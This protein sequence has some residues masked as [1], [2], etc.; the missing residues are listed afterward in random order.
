MIPLAIGYSETH[1][2]FG[3]ISPS[4]LYRREPEVIFDM[5]ARLAPG[6]DLPVMLLLNNIHCFP[7]D[8][9]SV[10][11]VVTAPKLSPMKI[12]ISSPAEFEIEHP[13]SFR[14]TLFHFTVP[15]DF[16]NKGWNSLVAKVEFKLKRR[17]KTVIVDNLFSSSNRPLS[18]FVAS[19]KFPGEDK[20][21]FGDFHTH[22]IHS[23][24][25]VEFGA[26]LATIIKMGEATGLKFTAVTDHSYDLECDPQNYL[27]RDP[28]LENWNV[29]Q[30]C[31]SETDSFTL[32]T[33]EEVSG[34]RDIGGVVHLGA[35][36]HN[37]FIKGSGDGARKK[38]RR[39]EEP[40]LQD[41]A[42]QVVEEGGITFAA[43][44]GEKTSLLQRIL[45]RRGNWVEN[46]LSPFVT[47]LQGI[48][49]KFDSFWYVTRKLW[50]KALLNGKHMPLIAGNDAHGD[51]NR[52]RAMGFPFLYIKENFERYYG[53][54]RTGIYGDD[55]SQ[56]ATLKAVKEGRT[57]ITDGPYVAICLEN[58]VVVGS[59]CS[60]D[61]QFCIDVES[62]EEFG[63]LRKITL[64]AGSYTTKKE[65][66][67]ILPS[68]KD[69]FSYQYS[70]TNDTLCD[71]DY[72][73]VE[74][75]CNEGKRLFASKAATSPVY[76]M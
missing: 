18:V 29:Q 65:R 28:T 1:F 36:G 6:N 22:S 4:L 73:R 19:D 48:N 44:P 33:G 62:T 50:V 30:D 59:Q 61:D 13:F 51:F 17:N 14:A 35:L 3:G 71:F 63:S 39:N 8:V 32:I 42:K 72:I 47:S 57:F 45:L 43:H 46:E 25:H 66:V 54:G 20:S 58:R 69:C 10:S 9:E 7:A 37:S 76:L 27:H 38:Y 53:L 67:W 75:E 68:E 5:P 12:E 56:S 49:G 16:L 60:R 70:I 40:S 31:A 26:P 21:L 2:R 15:E 55:H 24:S 52:Y 11:L 64:I 23:W 74:V 41:A 34:R